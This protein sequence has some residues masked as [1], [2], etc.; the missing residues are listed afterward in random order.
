MLSYMTTNEMPKSIA[1]Q[2]G[3]LAQPSHTP[4]QKAL[5]LHRD[6]LSYLHLGQPWNAVKA[7]EQALAILDG[8]GR[9]SPTS[10]GL[11]QNI[12]RTLARAQAKVGG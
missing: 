5:T 3:F 4:Y 11:Q 8:A 7:E 6:A 10:K 1:R 2:L 9:L 12:R